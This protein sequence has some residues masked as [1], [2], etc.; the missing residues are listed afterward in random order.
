M[1]PACLATAAIIAAK[2][3]ASGGAV[4][5]VAVK[6]LR[7]KPATKSPHPTTTATTGGSR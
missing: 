7:P 3:A 1:C 6:L 2:A 4:T 5:A